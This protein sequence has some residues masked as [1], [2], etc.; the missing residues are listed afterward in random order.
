M[1]RKSAKGKEKKLKRKEETAKM[2]LSLVKVDNCN[3]M[4][5]PLAPFVVFKKFD[6]NGLVAK[7][8][9][10][11]V[12]D[13]D[14]Q[15]IDWAFELTKTN[16]KD[17][18]AQSEWGWKDREKKDEMIEH[19]AWYLV[20]RDNDDKP[21]AF[22]HFRFDMEFDEEVLYLYE[23]QLVPEIRKKGLG[24][25]LVLTLEL[26][27]NKYDM[28]KVMLTSFKHNKEGF[29]FFKALK[30]DVDEISPEARVF[31][32]GY[33][34]IIMS[35]LTKFGKEQ[36]AKEDAMNELEENNQEIKEQVTS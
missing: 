8:E 9:C 16:M 24:K 21:I 33:D 7:I 20:A 11:R 26:M 5:D 28:R 32:E 15:T 31:E 14:K 6:R 23:I 10:K 36:K 30:Y 22:V 19:K 25:F 1:G 2:K 35:K 13:L 27:A 17:L 29:D 12:G 18:Y 4:E 34:Y 3:K